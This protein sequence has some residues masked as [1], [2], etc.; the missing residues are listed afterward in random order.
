MAIKNSQ[1]EIDYIKQIKSNKVPFA[2]RAMRSYIK[3]LNKIS[4][5][6]ATKLVTKLFL[7]P[8][9]TVLRKD[10]LEY[11]K[12]GHSEFIK[13]ND[14]EVFVFTKGEGP[15]VMLAH[16]WGSNSYIFRFI[17]DSLV[18]SGYSV[19]TLD[20][21]AHGQSSGKQTTLPE[22]SELIKLL[23]EKYGPF[24]AAIA[25]SFGGPTTIR[26]LELGLQT[27]NLILLSSPTKI[28][29]IFN[30]FFDLLDVKPELQE[31]FIQDL[32]AQTGIDRNRISPL[33]M[34]YDKSVRTLIVHDKDDEIISHTDATSI[35]NELKN[36]KL[37]FTSKLGHRGVPRTEEVLREIINFLA[38]TETKIN[39]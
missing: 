16:G 21:P 39:L 6:R 9:R 3:F 20:Y 14:K 11:Y 37:I 13:F 17:M 35:H 23:S 2:I 4:K 27:E 1:T 29:S 33:D 7:T 18:E 31:L 32:V 8:Q 19:V 34:E 12:S 25:Y 26:A 28:E 36:S 30:P 5:K 22:T 15:R 38:M 24:K 10:Q